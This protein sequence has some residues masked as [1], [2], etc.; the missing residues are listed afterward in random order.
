MRKIAKLFATLLFIGYVPLAPGTAASLAAL[1]VYYLL[2]QSPVL[3]FWVTLAFLGLGFWAAGRAEK[4]FREKDPPQI[5]IDEFASTLLVFLFIPFSVKFMVLGFAL[6]R[7][8][9]IIK[10][11][12]IKRLERLPAGSGIM[13]DDIASAVLSNLILQVLR[14][15]PL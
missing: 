1:P 15:L 8:L 3:Y 14:F 9:D 11:P 4:A 5:V 2:R 6:F 13:L 7:I 10:I 12:P